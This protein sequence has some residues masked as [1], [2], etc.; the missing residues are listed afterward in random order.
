M[1]YS[2]LVKLSH[3]NKTVLNKK[4]ED[5]LWLILHQILIK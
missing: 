5:S 3:H 4:E 1:V 2:R